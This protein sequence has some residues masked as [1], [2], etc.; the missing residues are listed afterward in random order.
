MTN[1][2]RCSRLNSDDGINSLYEN[3]K[4]FIVIGLTGR[5]GSGCSSAAE[6][7]SKSIVQVKLPKPKLCGD[8]YE[9]K[10]KII[11]EF[12]QNNWKAFHWIQIKDV[13]TSFIVDNSFID[14]QTYASSVLANDLFSDDQIKD[15]L[16]ELIEEEYTILH[17]ERIKLNKERKE[18][19]ASLIIDKQKTAERREK[20]HKFYFEILPPFTEKLKSI[21]NQLGGNSYTKMYQL[22][23]DNIRASGTAFN[24]VFDSKNIYRLSIRVNKIIKI[25]TNRARSSKDNVYVV[26]DTFRNPFEAIFFKERYAAFYLVSINTKNIHREHRLKKILH[27]TDIQLSEIDEKESEKDHDDENFFISQNIPKCIEI[28]DIH[29]NNPHQLGIGS[30]LCG[31]TITPISQA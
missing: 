14:F 8:E 30:S 16:S 23:G 31:H 5:T 12:A 25:F 4:K 1:R 28:S 3:R 21:L 26:I 13:I 27:L 20:S 7:L 29:I 22:I 24:N 18:L 11:Y 9:R 17:D 6:I 10:Y 2:L 15:R 19:E